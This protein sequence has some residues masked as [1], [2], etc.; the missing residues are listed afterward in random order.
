[1]YGLVSVGVSKAAEPRFDMLLHCSNVHSSQYLISR[2]V[3]WEH[4]NNS[5]KGML[6]GLIYEK[7]NSGRVCSAIRKK[8]SKNNNK[9]NNHLKSVT[10]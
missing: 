1:M 9:K 3:I 5:E 6:K 4:G 7:I 8:I 2:N 10:Q